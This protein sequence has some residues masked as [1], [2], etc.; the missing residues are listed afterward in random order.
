VVALFLSVGNDHGH[1]PDHL[2]ERAAC[3]RLP[4]DAAALSIHIMRRWAD[5]LRH[6]SFAPYAAQMAWLP[7]L[8]AARTPMLAWSAA[9]ATPKL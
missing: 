7:W 5:G 6:G 9:L 3:A 4:A 2:A 1:W 8:E